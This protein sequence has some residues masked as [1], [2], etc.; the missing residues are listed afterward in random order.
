V[1]DGGE[2]LDAEVADAGPVERLDLPFKRQRVSAVDGDTVGGAA[3][4]Q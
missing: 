1:V 2:R 4:V 3:Q